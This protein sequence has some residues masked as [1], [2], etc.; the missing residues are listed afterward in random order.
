MKWW[1]FDT[2]YV[3]GSSLTAGGGMN[4]PM[5]KT[6]YKRLLNIDIGD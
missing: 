3:N 6:E 1:K 2:I 4:V 5:N